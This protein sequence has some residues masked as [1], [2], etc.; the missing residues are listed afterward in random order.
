MGELVAMP[1]DHASDG[2][3]GLRRSFRLHSPRFDN[4]ID[5]FALGRVDEAAGIHDDQLRGRRVGDPLGAV[6]EELREVALRVD[7]V[8][9][10]AE[11]DEGN[12]HR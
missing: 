10:A 1:L 11:G 8:L 2:H 4:C 12:A 9:V 5:R 6:I 3:H 7:G